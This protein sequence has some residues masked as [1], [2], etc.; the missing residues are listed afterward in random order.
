[1]KAGTCAV[2]QRTHT[3][4]AVLGII[5]LVL[6]LGP[7]VAAPLT[8]WQ[9]TASA[10]GLSALANSKIYWTAA[11]QGKIQRANLDGSSV[12]DLVTGLSTPLDL[13]LDLTGGKMYWTDGQQGKIQRAS[14]NGTNVE[15]LVSGL[16]GPAGLALDL[17]GGRMY[18]VI[19]GP[20][21]A[22]AIA[23]LI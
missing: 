20:Q 9:P 14:L 13:A 19:E 17:T 15:T 18:Y 7:F 8:V 11:S 21:W 10:A 16:T 23:A 2:P 4:S 22:G 6:I 5:M 1:M 3:P 12:E